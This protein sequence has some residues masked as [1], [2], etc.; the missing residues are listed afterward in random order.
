LRE[1]LD[2]GPA[3][4]TLQLYQT[5]RNDTLEQSP[6]PDIGVQESPDA[7]QLSLVLAHL[8]QF[9]STLSSMQT[10]LHHDIQ[11]V[12]LALTGETPYQ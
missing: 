12:Q 10:N 4:L 5:I 7:T 3:A 6:L 11:V 1:E 9:Q 8:Q 2:V